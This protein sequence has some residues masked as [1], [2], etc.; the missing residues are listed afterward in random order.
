MLATLDRLALFN[1][2]SSEKGESGHIHRLLLLICFSCVKV[3][4]VWGADK[5]KH[6]DVK[7]FFSIRVF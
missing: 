2:A 6:M 3:S 5:S 4:D 1:E 7:C